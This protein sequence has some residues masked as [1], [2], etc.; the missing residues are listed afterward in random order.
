MEI[1]FSTF[2]IKR[3]TRRKFALIYN[4]DSVT[5]P[6]SHLEMV[7]RAAHS[8]HGWEPGR[9][10]INH[11]MRQFGCSSASARMIC[12]YFNL[13]ADEIKPFPDED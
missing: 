3:L 8:T 11:V 4:V 12:Q 10:R 5:L 9:T 7:F 1:L 6:Y 13:D 2:S